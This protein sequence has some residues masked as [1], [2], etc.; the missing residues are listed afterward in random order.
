MNHPEGILTRRDRYYI[1][2]DGNMYR[3][4][5]KRSILKV[6]ADRKKEVKSFIRTNY[7]DFRTNPDYQLTEVVRYYDSLN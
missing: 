5:K 6:L 7:F 1:R 3:V 4:R 2:K